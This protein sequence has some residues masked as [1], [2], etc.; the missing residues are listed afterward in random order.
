MGDITAMIYYRNTEPRRYCNNKEYYIRNYI[1]HE[2]RETIS[3][4]KTIK[5][6]FGKYCSIKINDI[7]YKKD[8]KAFY[9]H[10]DNEIQKQR[11]WEILANE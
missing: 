7:E 10:F 8:T 4:R 3:L 5:N 2:L 11:T 9:K 6:F 1:W